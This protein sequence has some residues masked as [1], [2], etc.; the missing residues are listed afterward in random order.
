MPLALPAEELKTLTDLYH[1]LGGPEWHN[2][3]NWL[4]TSNPC[5]GNGTTDDAWYGVECTTL[6]AVPFE[7]NSSTHVKRLVLPQNNLTGN[8]PPLSDLKHL[9]LLDFS[10]PSLPEVPTGFRNSVG[11]TLDALCGLGNLSTILLAHN[12]I[13]GILPNCIQSLANATVLNLDYNAIQGTTPNELC[14]LHNLE[15]LHLR[16]NRLQG[17]VPVCIGEALTALRILD[18]SNL[19][20]DYRVVSQSLFGTLPTSLC[21]LEHLEVLLF[22][23]THGLHGT[24]P[25]H[26]SIP[27]PNTRRALSGERDSIPASVRECLDWNPSE[28]LGEP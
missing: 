17:T 26:E 22:Q 5:G 2:K 16:G 19:D 8:L 27:R 4:S 15:E 11:G 28:L 9:F 10:N 6:E 21:D 13:S 23:D 7:T 12:K 1:S 14:R 24:L 25:A 3:D 20:E 18:Y